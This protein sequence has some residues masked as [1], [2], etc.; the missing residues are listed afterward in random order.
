MTLPFTVPGG[1]DLLNPVALI[2]LVLAVYRITRL[3]VTDHIFDNPRNKLFDKFPPD[4]SMFGYLFTC[5]WCMSIWVAS[6][7]TVPYTIIPAATLVFSFPFALS[8]VAA[9]IAARVDD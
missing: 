9:I 7:L 6:L 8:A 3:I 1:F 4:R 5:N 2:V